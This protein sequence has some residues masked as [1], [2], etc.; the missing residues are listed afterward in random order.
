MKDRIVELDR[1]H[2]VLKSYKRTLSDNT[3]HP[4][5]IL[6]VDRVREFDHL[7]YIPKD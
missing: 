6:S 1:V 3:E 2:A 5:F 7:G 4:D